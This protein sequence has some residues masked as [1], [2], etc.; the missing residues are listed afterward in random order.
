MLDLLITVM[1]G[2]RIIAASMV[3]ALVVMVVYLNLAS[4]RYTGELKVTVTQSGAGSLSSSLRNLS[5]LASIAGIQ[6]PQD[7]GEIA[8][9]RYRETL[10]SAAAARALA[11]DEHLMQRMFRAEWDE[12]S[13]R[14][15][16]R[17]G[18][19]GGIISLGKRLLGVPVYAW[20]EPDSSRVQAYLDRR[21]SVTQDQR[22]PLLVI[23]FQDE[24]PEFARHFLERLHAEVDGGLRRRALEQATSNIAYLEQ[25]LQSTSVAEHR[26]A[27]SEA[28]GEQERVR[29]LAESGADFA[30]EP[31]GIVA[32]S[33]RPTFPRPALF[34]AGALLF[35]LLC[36]AVLTLV[37][38]WMRSRDAVQG[39]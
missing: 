27:L 4:Y 17:R 5:G 25:K 3:A 37:R 16:E 33:D 18:V 38:A 9:L 6:L 21:V 13:G 30:A 31:I 34:L 20:Q 14:F 29:M 2:W 1:R 15:V 12:E 36:G 39:P 11:A 35:G 32:V 22:R 7:G 23:T 24:D 28:L 26:A 10:R 19:I 8:F